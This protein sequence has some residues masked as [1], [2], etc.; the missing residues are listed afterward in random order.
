MT[1]ASVDIKKTSYKQLKKLLTAF[2]KK[3]LLGQKLI[4]KQDNLA[5]VNRQ[6]AL[7]LGFTPPADGDDAAKVNSG[8]FCSDVVV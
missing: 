3:G 6:H 7:Y 4:H 8:L 1:G 2:E 5:S